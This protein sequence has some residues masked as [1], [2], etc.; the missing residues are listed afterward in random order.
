VKDHV[1]LGPGPEFDRVRAILAA[2]G[3]AGAPSGEDVAL[4]SVGGKTLALSTDL[5]IEGTHFLTDWL[6]LE[7]IGW[8]SAA[9]A[10]SDLA[11]V[12]ATPLGV[13]VALGVPADAGDVDVAAVMRGVGQVTLEVDARVL[14][15]DLSKAP[16]WTVAVTVIG[17]VAKP[18]SRAGGTPGDLL[19]VTGE[20]GGA[21]AALQTWLHRKGRDMHPEARERFAHPLPRI[22]AGRALSAS[23][24]AMM[25]LSDGLAADAWHIAAASNCGA[26]IELDTLPVA[27]A[28]LA[29]VKGSRE[30]AALFAAEGGEDYELL[31]ALPHGL[32]PPILNVKLTRVGRLV[33]GDGVQFLSG[34]TPV[35]PK[36]FQ[37]FR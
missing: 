15:G 4:L 22:A 25:D 26:V 30:D 20:L 35:L 9:A 37:H 3:E 34:S 23:A 27:A 11:A 10:L 32:E 8:R 6:T 16:A 7:E 13:L 36:G 2:L 33:A 5:S 19:Y 28:A 31:V 21:H 17:E 29:F 1:Q 14:G 12:G 24:T 18:T